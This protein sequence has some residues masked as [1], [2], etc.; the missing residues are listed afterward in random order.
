MGNERRTGDTLIRIQ[1]AVVGLVMV[2]GM[3]MLI[4]PLF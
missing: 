2:L 1:V 4:A 3:A